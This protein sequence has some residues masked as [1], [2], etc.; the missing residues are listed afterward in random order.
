VPRNGDLNDIPLTAKK[1]CG[2]RGK[3]LTL[4][5][6]G[7][8]RIRTGCGYQ[9]KAFLLGEVKG[10]GKVKQ[11]AQKGKLGE[12]SLL[13]N[14]RRKGLQIHAEMAARSMKGEWLQRNENTRT[15]TKGG[16]THP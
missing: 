6:A 2:H 4:K 12:N 14:V 15:A 13:A 8:K 16:L 11:Q 7:K 3:G 1:L 9:G 5:T 10:K